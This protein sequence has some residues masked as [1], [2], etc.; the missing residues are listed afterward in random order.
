MSR[1]CVRTHRERH[2]PP[3]LRSRSSDFGLCRAR[4]PPDCVPAPC[5]GSR[6]RV[7][8]QPQS[9]AA[10][11]RTSCHFEGLRSPL[12]QTV[13]SAGKAA[14]EASTRFAIGTARSDHPGEQGTSALH[15]LR[16]SGF[17][18][19]EGGRST[20]VCRQP[21]FSLHTIAEI[22]ADHHETVAA[23]GNSLSS[24]RASRHV[25]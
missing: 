25:G 16:K 11:A 18:R 19:A 24:A 12:P 4:P 5:F 21:T 3:A 9:G 23:N 20:P 15:I 2:A 14:F 17:E 1:A 13:K 6:R 10:A 8:T 7:F 22:A